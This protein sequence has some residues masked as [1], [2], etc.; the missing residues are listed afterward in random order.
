[1]GLSSSRSIHSVESKIL[2]RYPPATTPKF[3]LPS[4]R[5]EQ[6]WELLLEVILGPGVKVVV[7]K[8][9]NQVEADFDPSWYPP[10]TKAWVELILK[11]QWYLIFT[12]KSSSSS[13]SGISVGARGPQ[14]GILYT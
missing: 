7:A 1:M 13:S 14:L 6:P 9:T 12:G 10:V 8:S 2:P 3:F 5:V 4:W 11:E